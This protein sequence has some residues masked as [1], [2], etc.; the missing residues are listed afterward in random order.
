MKT[1]EELIWESYS[2]TFTIKQ[3]G[4]RKLMRYSK[5]FFKDK[6]EFLSN[7]NNHAELMY[8]LTWLSEGTLHHHL[9]GVDVPHGG[10]L[11]ERKLY[12]EFLAFVKENEKSS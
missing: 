3:L 6:E 8:R 11:N 4:V 12:D 1:E 10:N 2:E 9:M 7:V 5:Q